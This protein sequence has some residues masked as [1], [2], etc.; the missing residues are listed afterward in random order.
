MAAFAVSAD[1]RRWSTSPTDDGTH[2]IIL[3]AFLTPFNGAKSQQ[4]SGSFLNADADQISHA[5]GSDVLVQAAAF[6]EQSAGAFASG[7]VTLHIVHDRPLHIHQSA[8]L[9]CVYFH[10]FDSTRDTMESQIRFRAA[11]TDRRW[12]LYAHLLRDLARSGVD[13]DCAWSV[14]LTD[15]VMLRLPPCATLPDDRI[16]L[17]R[18]G[19]PERDERKWF[20]WLGKQ[21]LANEVWQGFDQFHLSGKQPILNNGIVG[22]RRAAFTPFLH[23]SSRAVTSM[24]LR[25]HL[26][27]NWSLDMIVSNQAVYDPNVRHEAGLAVQRPIIGYPDGPVNLPMWGELERFN[28]RSVSDGGH[29]G[30]DTFESRETGFYR[31]VLAG[32]TNTTFM[33]GI[34]SVKDAK[35]WCATDRFNCRHAHLRMTRGMYWFGHKLPHHWLLAEFGLRPSIH[36]RSSRCKPPDQG[37]EVVLTGADCCRRFVGGQRFVGSHRTTSRLLHQTHHGFSSSPSGCEDLCTRMNCSLF[38]WNREWHQCAFCHGLE[39]P[40]ARTTT[41]LSN[42]SSVYQR[43][44]IGSSFALRL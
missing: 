10:H 27:S 21:A 12:P 23:F 13:W 22:G 37:F 15:V 42:Q 41:R 30:G 44:V 31:G 38:S 33:N 40:F 35:W 43:K 3:A 8:E 6:I 1:M 26:R 5:S 16:A 9:P 29:N 34:I 19:L 17:G 18:D 11:A 20:G 28:V 4:I 39:C 36:Q 7:H 14:D 32:L 2:T 25:P 24:W